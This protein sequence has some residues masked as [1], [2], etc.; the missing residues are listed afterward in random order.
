[1]A[2]KSEQEQLAWTRWWWTSANEMMLKHKLTRQLVV[3]AVQKANTLPRPGA[4]EL[5]ETCVREGVPVVIVS[6]G[7]NCVIEEFLRVHDKSGNL[8]Q[9]P[10]L[11]IHANQM[12]FDAD[13]NLVGFGQNLI[14]TRNKRDSMLLAKD[15]FDELFI[16]RCLPGPWYSVLHRSSV[17][18]PRA[19]G[20]ESRT[21]Q[22]A[23]TRAH[24]HTHFRKHV[25]LLG[26]NINDADV[27]AHVPSSVTTVKVAFANRSL[28]KVKIFECGRICVCPRM[29]V[30]V[31]WCHSA[32]S[33]GLFV[34]LLLLACLARI[35]ALL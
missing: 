30:R 25:L 8:L 15:F 28:I 35:A 27:V 32:F 33:A 18:F 5:L 24:T 19:H 22:M 7:L 12:N 2:E 14:T 20:R 17:L 13:G 21:D 11:S 16:S 31:S 10:L 3:E 23:R 26:D 34:S 4:I 9:S 29:S 6:A 1:M